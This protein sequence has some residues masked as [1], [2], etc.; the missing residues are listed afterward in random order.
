MSCAVIELIRAAFSRQI[1]TMGCVSI[2]FP[3][4]RFLVYGWKLRSVN[5]GERV[6][7]DELVAIKA[8]AASFRGSLP[9]VLDTDQ[10]T[11][12]GVLGLELGLAVGCQPHTP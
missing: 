6:L 4:T 2:E 5:H 10:R 8:P 11:G 1:T 12:P 3:N 9:Q 7:H